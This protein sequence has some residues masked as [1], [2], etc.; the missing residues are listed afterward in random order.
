MVPYYFREHLQPEQ[1][2]LLMAKQ[3]LEYQLLP[4]LLL[5]AQAAI[6]QATAAALAAPQVAGGIL[7]SQ[8][9]ACLALPAVEL[10]VRVLTAACRSEDS[11]TLNSVLWNVL[12]VAD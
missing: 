9:A 12:D 7:T 10:A 5:A 4:D 8:H 6:Q 1:H 3:C 2:Q 11:W